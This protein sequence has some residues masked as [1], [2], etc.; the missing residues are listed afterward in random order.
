MLAI[1]TDLRSGRAV[2]PPFVDNLCKDFGN[3]R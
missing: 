2:P 1:A 3:I